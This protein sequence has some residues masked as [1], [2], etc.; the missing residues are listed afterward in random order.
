MLEKYIDEQE[1]V[2]KL[3][4]QSLKEDK[5]VQ[6]YLFCCD[7]INYIYN[8]SKEFAKS[9]ISLSDIEE[10]I[11]KNIFIRIDKEEYSELKIV[12]PDGNF[13]KKEQLLELQNSVLN[14]PIEGNKIIYIIKNCEKLNASS[15]NSI[16]KFLEEPEDDIIAILLT[17]N[18]NMVIPTIKSRCQVVN[19]KNMKNNIHS[20]NKLIN[21]IFDDISNITVEDFDI[22]INNVFKFVETIEI[23]RK[24][25]FIYIRKLAWDIFDN[26]EEIMSLL[27]S[28]LYLYVDSLY[29]TIGKKIKYFADYEEK[30]KLI[31]ENNDENKIVKKISIVEKIKSELKMNINTKLLFDKLIIELSEV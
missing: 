31:S 18:I 15:A 13:I 16:L 24:N 28:I 6:A 9:I 25:T 30:V 22:F 4:A 2:T 1:I 10:P 3:L 26:S 19:F 23:K 12:E 20:N 8:Y 27:S 11:L 7:D 17:D 5:I 29:Y 21:F 14:K